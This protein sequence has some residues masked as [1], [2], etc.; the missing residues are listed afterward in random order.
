MRFH[1]LDFDLITAILHANVSKLLPNEWERLLVPEF[2]ERAI[3]SLAEEEN[4][5]AAYEEGHEAALHEVFLCKF[6][7][8]NRLRGGGFL[9]GDILIE[10]R[11]SGSVC[12]IR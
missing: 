4:N 12:R 11:C 7:R 2:G 1:L 6:N 5:K 10:L 3:V 8:I 9:R